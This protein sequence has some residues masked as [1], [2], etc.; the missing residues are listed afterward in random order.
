MKAHKL[1]IFGL[2]LIIYGLAA[3]NLFI[4]DKPTLST[5]E[6]RELLTLPTYSFE[7]LKSGHFFKNFDDY[8]ADNFIFRERFVA[9]GQEIDGLKGYQREEK[10]AIVETYGDNTFDSGNEDMNRVDVELENEDPVTILFKENVALTLHKFYPE[11]AKKYAVALNDFADTIDP[12]VQIYSVLI[13]DRIEFESD[14]SLKALSDSEEVTIQY[15]NTLLSDRIAPINI[16]DGIKAKSSDYI[17]FNTDHH[18]TA[19]GAYYGYSAFVSALGE[20]PIPLS[21]YDRERFNNFLGSRYALNNNLEKNPDYVDVFKYKE[22]DSLSYVVY[23]EGAYEE[24]PLLDMTF[25]ELPNK[26]GVFLGGD[27]P[28]SKVSRNIPDDKTPANGKKLLIIKDSYGNAFTPFIAPHYDETYIVDPRYIDDSID[29]RALIDENQ[30]DEVL[31]INTISVTTKNGFPA[32]ISG[33]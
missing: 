17:Y 9:L 11:K 23:R 26:Y 1:N 16:Y 31:F 28:L 30:I 10:L 21:D 15:V 8:F 12:S 14:E 33:L 25:K 27:W 32:I 3:V 4:T 5:I 2:L 29:V 22:L 19:L 7:D 24:A 20:T 18:W 13:P 6:N